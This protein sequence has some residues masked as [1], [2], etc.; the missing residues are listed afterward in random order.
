MTQMKF[1][2]VS[3]MDSWPMGLPAS[4]VYL[5]HTK[6]TRWPNYAHAKS[7]KILL[8]DVKQQNDHLFKSL[9]I[10]FA[11][12]VKDAT[13][14]NDYYAYKGD[15]HRKKYTNKKYT[16]TA[17]GQKTFAIKMAKKTKKETINTQDDVMS[18]HILSSSRRRHGGKKTKQV[19][20]QG[21]RRRAGWRR[22]PV[23]PI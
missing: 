7:D 8:V 21:A 6:M 17:Y 20:L 16:T 15:S 4:Y 14:V 13:T 23:G 1:N 3:W 2:T 22:I 18:M 5:C 9:Q 10:R 12:D 19:S 11:N